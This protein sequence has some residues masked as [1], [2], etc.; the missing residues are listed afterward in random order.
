MRVKRRR[1]PI[2]RTAAARYRAADKDENICAKMRAQI[3]SIWRLFLFPSI[4]IFAP[5]RK[6]DYQAA[7]ASFQMNPR[8][9]II[10]DKIDDKRSG[11][12]REVCAARDRTTESSTARDE[13]AI[14]AAKA[15]RC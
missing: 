5:A 9:T 12:W 3:A 15:Q 1:A 14:W 13:S 6:Q 11:A 2:T 10:F 4:S 7:V 8:S